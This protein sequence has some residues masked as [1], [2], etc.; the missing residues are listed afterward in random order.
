MNMNEQFVRW[1]QKHGWFKT[2]LTKKEFTNLAYNDCL[3]L[4][5][6]ATKNYFE[7]NGFEWDS[8]GADDIMDMIIKDFKEETGNIIE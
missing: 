7:L 8:A 1:G 5:E 3:K 2:K 6:I 4:V